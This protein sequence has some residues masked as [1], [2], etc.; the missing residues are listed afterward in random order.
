MP[1]AVAQA[2]AT[3]ATGLAGTATAP[4][5]LLPLALAVSRCQWRRWSLR[6][7]RSPA[8]L[9]LPVLP[10]PVWWVRRGELSPLP[11]RRR[12]ESQSESE[13][14]TLRARDSDSESAPEPLAAYRGSAFRM[15]LYSTLSSDPLFSP[16]STSFAGS[17]TL[18][19][20]EG[21]KEAP[22]SASERVRLNR[23]VIIA[24]SE[25]Q[26]MVLMSSLLLLFAAKRS[27][28]RLASQEIVASRCGPKQTRYFRPRRLLTKC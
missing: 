13:S 22:V 4:V 6:Q 5:A 17:R 9:A 20:D 21:Q 1:L 26:A 19:Q 3:G 2:G 28:P 8:A 16:S 18:R 23:A 11:P 15:Q 12:C 25:P 14:A 24:D 27:G 10:V 7:A